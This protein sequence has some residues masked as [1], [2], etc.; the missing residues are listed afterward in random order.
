M[1]DDSPE[2]PERCLTRLWV[3]H[4]D[5]E[6]LLNPTPLVVHLYPVSSEIRMIFE[7]HFNVMSLIEDIRNLMFRYEEE[8][9]RPSWIWEIRE[10]ELIEEEV[11]SKINQRRSQLP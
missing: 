3:F 8:F 1:R 10:T 7:I 9:C 6:H 5:P 4:N 11:E 2:R